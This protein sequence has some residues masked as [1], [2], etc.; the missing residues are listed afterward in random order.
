MV[1]GEYGLSSAHYLKEPFNTKKVRSS[2]EHGQV[3]RGEL[4]EQYVNYQNMS[5]Y[6]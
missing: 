3:H 1:D 4:L 6:R 2:A 5:A